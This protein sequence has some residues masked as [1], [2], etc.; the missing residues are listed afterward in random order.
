MGGNGGSAFRNQFGTGRARRTGT[1]L[2]ACLM[3]AGLLAACSSSS[4]SSSTTAAP[5]GKVLL[6][7]TFHGHAGQYTSIQSAVNAAKP[8]DWVLVAPGDYHE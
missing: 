4:S 7:G 3:G 5:S 6:V 2:A 1:A 8:G